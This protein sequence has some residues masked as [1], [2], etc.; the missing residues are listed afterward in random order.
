MA[1]RGHPLVELPADKAAMKKSTLL[2][3]FLLLVG[4]SGCGQNAEP[5]VQM[6]EFDL[7]TRVRWVLP[8]NW[9]LEQHN[10]Q[11]IISRKDPVRSHGCIGLDLGWFRH[12]ESLYAFIDKWGTD[13]N[14]K[15]RLRLGPRVDMIQHAQLTESNSK[16]LVTKGTILP[17]REFYESE[18]LHSY[19][20]SYRQVPDYYDKDSSVYVESNLHPWDCIFPDAVAR[21]CQSV[22]SG[23]DLVFSR[24]PGIGSL[25]A[26][27]WLGE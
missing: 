11:L 17:H 8:P 9:T 25:T 5:P 13:V 3:V 22:L 23:L 19:D 14:Y 7:A 6:S 15:I 2:I 16:I 10:Q 24:Y 21:E 1:P 27:S 26:Q 12:R 18:A 4:R 20:P